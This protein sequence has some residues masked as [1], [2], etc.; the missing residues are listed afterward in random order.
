MKYV[1]I[2][3]LVNTHGLKGEVRILS[4]FKYKDRVFIPGM[5]IYIGKEKKEEEIISY[6][7][8]KMF[9]MIMMKGYVCIPV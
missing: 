3:K 6:R 4:N 1:L 9:E 8:H 7:H 5:K 2:G